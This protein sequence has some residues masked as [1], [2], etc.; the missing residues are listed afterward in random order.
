M[1]IDLLKSDNL[2]LGEISHRMNISLCSRSG[3]IIEPIVMPQWFLDCKEMARNASADL[4][5]GKITIEPEH[6]HAIWHHFMNNIKDWCISRQLWWGHQIP[7]YKIAFKERGGITDVGVKG[8]DLWIAARS[9]NEAYRKA[10]LQHNLESHQITLIRDSDVLDT[11]FSS[12]LFPLSVFGWPNCDLDFKKFYPLSLMETGSD[13]L[14]FWVSRMVML[15]TYLSGENPFKSIF[16]HPIVRDA[17]GVKMS[18]SLGNV[19]DPIH[20]IEG[21]SLSGLLENLRNGNLDVM[22]REK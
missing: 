19:I 2:Y 18:K 16:L 3:D 10:K 13:I 4:E 17:N 20:V 1:V 14:F 11:W 22:E 5:Q 9:E 6:H 21:I 8:K 7:A 12:A 15:C